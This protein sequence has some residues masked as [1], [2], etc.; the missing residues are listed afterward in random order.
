MKIVLGAS[1]L[2]SVLAMAAPRPASATV[3]N[4]A[5]TGVEAV[6]SFLNPENGIGA[7][8]FNLATVSNG[9]GTGR[10]GSFG[11]GVAYDST[12]LSAL[13]GV[14]LSGVDFLA[15]ELNGSPLLGFEGSKWLFSDGTDTFATE[16]IPGGPLQPGIVANVS[17]SYAAYAAFFGLSVPI[18]SG[19]MNFLLFDLP[20][21]VDT[22]SPTFTVEVSKGG[23][24]DGGTPDIDAMGVLVPE[25][26][27]ALLVGLGLLAV[28]TSRRRRA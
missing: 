14:S 21:A 26:T 25:P 2:V 10:F 28:V 1:I 3:I 18:G 7:P 19:D 5:G 8:D 15:V 24:F 27:T 12:A 23:G 11:S 16:H 13:L 9:G 6:A 20:D 4:W 17:V 22:L